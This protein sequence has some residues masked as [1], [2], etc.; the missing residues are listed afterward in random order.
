V[1]KQGANKSRKNKVKKL[2]HSIEGL[3]PLLD[4]IAQIDEV[5]AVLPLSI[6]PKAK[7]GQGLRFRISRDDPT[8][9]RL[10][11]TSKGAAQAVQITCN[12]EDRGAVA[13]QLRQLPEFDDGS[14]HGRRPRQK[15]RLADVPPPDDLFSLA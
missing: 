13:L 4:K 5:K 1:G 15:M 6:V 10:T 7:A 8:G 2:H 11:A 3:Y 14:K 12:T 9:L